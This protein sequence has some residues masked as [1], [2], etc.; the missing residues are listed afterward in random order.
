M[1]GNDRWRRGSPVPRSRAHA[2]EEYPHHKDLGDFGTVSKS[3][4][5]K[6][7]ALSPEQKQALKERFQVEKGGQPAS[8][9]KKSPRKGGYSGWTLFTKERL[10]AAKAQLAE[11]E[12]LDMALMMKQLADAWKALPEQERES[13]KARAATMPPKEQ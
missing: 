2:Q 3:I 12:A 4:A 8:P 7:H 1:G 13:Y 10:G 5:A 11:D 6:Y 9:K